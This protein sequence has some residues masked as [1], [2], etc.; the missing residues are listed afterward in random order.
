MYGNDDENLTLI[1]KFYKHAT[2]FH[3]L[4]VLHVNRLFICIVTIGS[5][6]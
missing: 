5:T 2:L 1:G 3:K 6:Q 4:S